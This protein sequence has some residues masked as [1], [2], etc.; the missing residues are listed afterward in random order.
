MINNVVLYWWGGHCCLMH[1]HL[2]KIYCAPQNLG[3][4][5]TWICRLNFVQRSIFSGL[6]FFNEPEISDSGPPACAQFFYVLKKSIDLSRVWTR[7]PWISRQAHYPEAEIFFIYI[8]V[9]NSRLHLFRSLQTPPLAPNIIFCFSN[10]QGA[11]F[12]LLS[13]RSS[14]L[15]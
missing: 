2:F 15:Q 7:E 3:I 12:F 9:I 4:T 6:R 11:V 14:V 8:P 1:C 13:L 10:H 5:R